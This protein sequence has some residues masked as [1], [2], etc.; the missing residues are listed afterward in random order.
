MKEEKRK[1]KA[2]FIHNRAVC[3]S[4]CRQP[5][6]IVLVVIIRLLRFRSIHFRPNAQQPSN[7]VPARSLLPRFPSCLCPLLPIHHKGK[8]KEGRKEGRRQMETEQRFADEHS[9]SRKRR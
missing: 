9:V 1:K 3:L 7:I 6:F 4:V 5:G 8:R 2:F